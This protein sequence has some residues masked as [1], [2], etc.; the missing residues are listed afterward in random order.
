M[1]LA[2]NDVGKKTFRKKEKYMMQVCREQ[3]RFS[4]LIIYDKMTGDKHAVAEATTSQD[5]TGPDTG[6]NHQKLKV[7]GF[8][9]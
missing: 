7:P 5:W 2:E 8:R 9:N 4:T 6:S 3:L 1:T